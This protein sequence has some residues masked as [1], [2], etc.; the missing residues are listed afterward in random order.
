MRK[1]SLLALAAL[2][3]GAGPVHAQATISEGMSPGQ[4]RAAF[5]EPATVRTA[6]EWSYWYYHN[7]C[8]RRCGSDDVVFF[9]GDRVVAAVLRTGARRF[10]GPRADRALEA[11][12]G[13]A[14]RQRREGGGVYVEP[15]EPVT[16]G[17]VRI[18]TAPARTVVVDAEVEGA[19]DL[20]VDGEPE[21][22]VDRVHERNVE[23]ARERESSVDRAR[24]LREERRP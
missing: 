21:T 11:A 9:Q 13:T 6:G 23:R 14:E 12:G 18:E 3:L 20:R 15:S 17:G 22:S 19:V 16:V 2:L 4:V 1:G 5:G 7:G 24:R 8:P 10:A